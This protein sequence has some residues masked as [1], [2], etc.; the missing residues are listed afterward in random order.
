MHF[1]I[2]GV[3]GKA[4]AGKWSLVVALPGQAPHEFR[5]VPYAKQD[6]RKLT[7][8]GFSSNATVATSFFLDNFKLRTK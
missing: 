8:V 3:A 2:T 5:E 7:W 6:F 1:E 4:N